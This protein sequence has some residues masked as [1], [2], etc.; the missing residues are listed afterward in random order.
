MTGWPAAAETLKFEKK[1]SLIFAWCGC[2]TK[3]IFS[4]GVSCDLKNGFRKPESKSTPASR[5][6]GGAR[7]G[8]GRHP[9]AF[10]HLELL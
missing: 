10:H 4:E 5:L 6:G 7:G 8:G 9:L 3:I 2:K 1:S